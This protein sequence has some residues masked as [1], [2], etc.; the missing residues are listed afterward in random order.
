MAQAA[1]AEDQRRKLIEKQKRNDYSEA[2]K[3][4]VQAREKMKNLDQ[5]L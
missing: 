1:M 4:E 3:S 2:L 5:M